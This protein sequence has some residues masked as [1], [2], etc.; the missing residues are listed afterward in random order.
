MGAVSAGGAPGPASPGPASPGR[1]G[2]PE[3]ET[4]S[5]AVRL[6]LGLDELSDAWLRLRFRLDWLPPVLPLT[7]TS[8]GDAERLV[9][10]G[11]AVARPPL[12]KASA[13]TPRW[14]NALAVLRRFAALDIPSAQVW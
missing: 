6:L 11:R 5:A 13:D 10:R 1:G 4:P 2:M 9:V 8:L 12:A 3:P 14:R 7:F